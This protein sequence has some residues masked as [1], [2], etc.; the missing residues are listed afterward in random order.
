VNAVTADGY[1]PL[2]QRDKIE[3]LRATNAELVGTLEELQD[4]REKHDAMWGGRRLLC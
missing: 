1:C 4:A 3:Y 2:C